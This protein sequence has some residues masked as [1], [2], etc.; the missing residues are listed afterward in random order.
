MMRE[1]DRASIDP[2]SRQD[3]SDRAC[4]HSLNVREG[5][6]EG[7]L[8]ERGRKRLKERAARFKTV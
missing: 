7:N 2:G 3:C 4:S 6:K 8:G 1:P 5:G